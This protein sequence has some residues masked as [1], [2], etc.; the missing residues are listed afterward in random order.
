MMRKTVRRW[1]ALAA[2]LVVVAMTALGGS[3][4]AGAAVPVTAVGWWTRSPSPPTVPAGGIAVGEAPDGDLSVAALRLSTGGGA[5]GV[6]LTLA[7]SSGE[8]KEAATLQVCTTT[9]AWNADSGTAITLAPR[10]N[11]PETPVLLARDSS[12]SWTADVTSLVGG[13][14]GDISIMIVPGPAPA[15][16]PGVAQAGAFQIAFKPPVVDGTVTPAAG[17]STSSPAS[18]PAPSTYSAPPA[19]AAPDYSV[20]T[21]PAFGAPVGVVPSAVLPVA[22]ASAV[23]SSQTAGGGQTSFP[24]NPVGTDSEGKSKLVIVGF[25]LLSILVGAAAATARWAQEQGVFDRLIPSGGGGSSL[26]PPESD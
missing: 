8:G 6:K 26:L 9:D 3:T 18:E 20:A 19:S 7:E 22:T 25:V 1:P 2:G 21:S 11:C 12:G 15:A 4:P 17:E 16:V 23:V 24:V 14:T 5:T 10:P 13:Q